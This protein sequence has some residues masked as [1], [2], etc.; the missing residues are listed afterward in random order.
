MAR[1][2]T[3]PDRDFSAG[4]GQAE[5]ALDPWMADPPATLDDL[6]NNPDI[7]A[8]V[9]QLISNALRQWANSD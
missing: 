9:G 3:N 4:H 5:F 2:S 8:R 7:R 1:L 6:F